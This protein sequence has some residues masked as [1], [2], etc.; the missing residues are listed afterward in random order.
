MQRTLPASAFRLALAIS[1]TALFTACSTGYSANRADQALQGHRYDKAVELY[2]KMI[3]E[4]NRGAPIY[5]ARAKAYSG[6]NIYDSALADINIAIRKDRYVP[7]HHLERG[8]ILFHLSDYDE[9]LSSLADAESRFRESPP[10]LHHL[11]ALIFLARDN[12]PAAETSLDRA[13]AIDSDFAPALQTRGHVRFLSGRSREALPDLNRAARIAPSS[14]LTFHSRGLVFHAL[15]DTRAA[16]ADLDRALFLRSPFPEANYN[17]A[18]LLYEEGENERAGEDLSAALEA[19]PDFYEARLLA[20]EVALA[21]HRHSDAVTHAR[22]AIRVHPDEIRP[23]RIIGQ[24]RLR[25]GMFDQGRA[26]FTETIRLGSSN[27]SDFIARG[28]LLE[29]SGND[30]AA[31]EDYSH[32]IKLGGSATA[33]AFEARGLLSQRLGELDAAVRDFTEAARLAPDR[34]G[35]YERLGTVLYEIGEHE[36]AYQALEREYAR[37]G[38]SRFLPQVFGLAA[39]HT[40][41]HDTAVTQLRTAIS[42]FPGD[43]VTLA[44]L[45]RSLF[46]LNRYDEALPIADEFILASNGS[47]IGFV[48]RGKAFAGMENFALAVGDFTHAIELDSQLIQAWLARGELYYSAGDYRR[49]LEDFEMA[50]SLEN[51]P[52]PE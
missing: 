3:E 44:A 6:L 17:R 24:A 18:R 34:I 48:L 27:Q 22:R 36:S 26:A 15:G 32:A 52:S 39:H 21:L 33:D 43:T 49:A 46:E 41:R 51:E 12:L 5:A 11:R 40:G 25:Q 14:S 29:L 4:G 7:A 16:L 1:L 19:S 45:T 9:A 31:R 30:D 8:R 47:P 13:I 20:A 23:W 50:K 38:G 35:I 37:D 2:T 42:R 10:D 28:R